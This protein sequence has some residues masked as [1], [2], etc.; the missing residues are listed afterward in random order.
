[1]LI[2]FRALVIIALVA[3]LAPL[4]VE[5]LDLESRRIEVVTRSGRL[6]D[7]NALAAVRVL[8]EVAA[9]V[10]ASITGSWVSVA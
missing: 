4:V 6:E 2:D 5:G 9:E 3:V 7:P 1:M 8:Q 10:E